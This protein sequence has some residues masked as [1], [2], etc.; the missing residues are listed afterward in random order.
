VVTPEQRRT[1]VTMAMEAAELTER[2]ACRYTGFSRSAQR[3]QARRPP[4]EELRARLHML[5]LLR[6]RWGYR[7]LY[8]LL[9]REGMQVNKKLVQ[10]VYRAEG[11]AVRR[12]KRKRVAVPRTPLPAPT[13]ANERWSMDFVSD[14]LGW[15]SPRE[16]SQELGSES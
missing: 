7:R 4:R 6:P 2:Q 9:R 8:R 10:R 12:R 13:R 14:A 15:S 3:Y 11:L 1:A 5:A 16:R